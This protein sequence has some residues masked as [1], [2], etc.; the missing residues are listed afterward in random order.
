MLQTPSKRQVSNPV[1]RLGQMNDEFG[2]IQ[3]AVLGGWSHGKFEN[4]VDWNA[5]SHWSLPPKCEAVCRDPR[6]GNQC[7]PVKWNDHFGSPCGVVN[8][9]NGCFQNTPTQTCALCTFPAQPYCCPF[10]RVPI[11]G[12]YVGEYLADS[13]S[14]GA[15]VPVKIG[16]PQPTWGGVQGGVFGGFQHGHYDNDVNWNQLS[17]WRSPQCNQVCRS[18]RR[19]N[20]CYPVKW[21]GY[22]G[23]P[24]GVVNYG[25]GCFQNVPT[26]TCALCTYPAQ[27]YCCPY[28]RIPICQG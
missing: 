24:C 10:E 12:E 19:Y 26:Q 7:F 22:Y 15:D 4:D 11:C 8:P 20:Q 1:A 16:L 13:G 28:W 3:G 25:N 9:S 23:P 18:P 2:G 5:L 6:R 14:G 27:P 17:T 21:S